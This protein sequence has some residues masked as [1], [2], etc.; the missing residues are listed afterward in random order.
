MTNYTFQ[1]RFV[2][3]IELGT[4]Q[5]T[6]RRFRPRFAGEEG[7]DRLKGHAKVGGP[8]GL[9]TGPR[10]Q[11]RKIGE[12]RALVVDPVRLDF[13]ADTVTAYGRLMTEQLTTGALLD[14]FAVRDGFAGWAEMRAFWRETHDAARFEGVRIF[15]G[16][17]FKGPLDH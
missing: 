16:D 12:A 14:G 1:A 15:W 17:T 3:P 10:F 6:I 9:M 2:I 7:R 5:Q 13:A 4:K 11:S 8:L